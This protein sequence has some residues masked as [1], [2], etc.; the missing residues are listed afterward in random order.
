MSRSW[1]GVYTVRWSIGTRPMGALPVAMP[2]SAQRVLSAVWAGPRPFHVPIEHVV[3]A[4]AG[5]GV[6]AGRL[7]FVVPAHPAD[8][9]PLCRA[10]AHLG[11]AGHRIGYDWRTVSTAKRAVLAGGPRL[12]IEFPV[13]SPCGGAC[14]P[15]C[16]CGRYLTLAHLQFS[17]ASQGRSLLEVA[18]LESELL[19]AV[20]D[21]REPFGVPRFEA[22]VKSV[23]DVLSVHGT[24]GTQA[25]RVRLLVDRVFTAALLIGSGFVPGPRGRSHVVR[26][27]LRNAATELALTGV[28]LTWLEG[29][30][31]VADQT[32]RTQLGFTPLTDYLLETVRAERE[33]FARVL[34]KA[35]ALLESAVTARHP[36]AEQAYA[37]LRLR[38]DHGIPLGVA[39]AWCREHGIA[40]SLRQLARLD[41]D[42]HV[43]KGPWPP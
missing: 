32:A 30:V 16:R 42:R 25:Q 2:P 14:G 5:V 1:G 38:S 6:D 35:P 15:G 11:M 31:Q 8:S 18:I 24:R 39:V 13:G 20:D 22:L 19:S 41:R 29:L 7:A 36:P 12:S 9:D 3:E 26:R 34:A 10:L 17:P 21:T 43:E 28:S 23:R 40:V 27:L 4:L 37:L 33:R